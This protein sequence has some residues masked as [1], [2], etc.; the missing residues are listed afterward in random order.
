MGL[1][2]RDVEGLRVLEVGSGWYGLGF[3]RLGAIV[4]HHNVATRTIAALREYAR[5]RNFHNLHCFE[6]D[7]VHDLLPEGQ[8]DIVYLSGVFQH[9]SCPAAALMNVSRALKTGGLLYVDHYRSGRWRWFVVDTLRQLARRRLLNDVVGRFSDTC[10]LGKDQSFELRQVELLVDDL[11]VEY[12][13]LFHPDDLIS[14][15]AAMGMAPLHPPTSM[16]LA[17]PLDAADHSLFFAHVFNTLVLKKERNGSDR[18]SRTRTMR[19]RN[20]IQEIAA[21]DGSYQAVAELTAE[22]LLTHESGRFSRSESVSQIV[23]LYRMAHPCLPEDPYFVSGTREGVDRNVVRG[24][25]S[26]ALAR[27]SA[28]CSFIAHKL[29]IRS[30]LPEY[31]VPSLGYELRRFSE[32]G[33]ALR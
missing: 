21:R 1:D 24:N 4:D 15:A 14:D 5:E 26:T 22:F 29:R 11:F 23:N 20:Q 10:A 32:A 33:E 18:C 9:L 30:P 31:S 27:H 2:P 12:V 25:D 6:T 8:F 19:G 3:H 16:D 28:W 7:L 13:H 17:D